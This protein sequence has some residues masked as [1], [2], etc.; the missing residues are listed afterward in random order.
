VSSAINRYVEFIELCTWAGAFAAIAAFVLLPFVSKHGDRNLIRNVV[1]DLFM[2][3]TGT[4]CLIAAGG[5]GACVLG[6][7]VAGHAI[8]EF[9]YKLASMPL[10]PVSDFSE[11]QFIYGFFSVLATGFASV[12]LFTLW[13]RCRTCFRKTKPTEF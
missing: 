8:C 10:D 1:N 9:G 6:G 5:T 2:V 11:L 7:Y 13:A 4:A 3:A 12:A